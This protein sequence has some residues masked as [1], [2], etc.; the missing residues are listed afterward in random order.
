MSETAEFIVVLVDDLST[1]REI[2]GVFELLTTPN[3]RLVA[4]AKGS[5][6]CGVN[7]RGRRPTLIIDAIK[8]REGYGNITFDEWYSNCVLPS[9]VRAKLIKL[10]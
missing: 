3:F 7:H 2:N 5:Q 9:A 1:Q 6:M 4:Y 10:R 8:E